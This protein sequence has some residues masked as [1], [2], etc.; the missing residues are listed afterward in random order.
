MKYFIEM[1]GFAFSR[2]FLLK[3]LSVVSL[4]ESVNQHFFIKAPPYM[5]L[6]KHE[7]RTVNYCENKLHG[8]YFYAGKTKIANVKQF[9]HSILQ[10]TD[11]IYVRGETKVRC[12][13]D[14]LGISQKIIDLVIY[15]S[16]ADVWRKMLQD[17]LD[18]ERV[19]S[20]L[21]PLPFHRNNPNCSH[22]KAFTSRL[23]IQN[24][25]QDEQMS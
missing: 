5:S 23:F 21:C 22:T 8:I 7:V 17:F 24:V 6:S 14:Q 4:D 1:E 11:I 19:E 18:S 12:L 9:L 25:N 10:P 13:R 2:K 3:E 20:N 16:K 15:E